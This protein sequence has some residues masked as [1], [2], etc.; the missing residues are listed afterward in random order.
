MEGLLEGGSGD[1]EK[2][3]KGRASIC[4]GFVLHPGLCTCYK[5]CSGRDVLKDTIG[6]GW[7]VGGP[8]YA[9]SHED[10]GCRGVMDY[11][12]PGYVSTDSAIQS[13]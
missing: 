3:W 7:N 1:H 8:E 10:H 12:V 9:R 2:C 5:P 6:E 4:Q 11:S 13:T